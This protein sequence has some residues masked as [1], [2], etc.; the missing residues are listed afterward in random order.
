MAGEQRGVPGVADHDPA[1]AL[2]EAAALAPV[3][4]RVLRRRATIE[5]HRAARFE[6]LIRQP[7]AV[8][9][10][11]VA[12][13][14]HVRHLLDTLDVRPVAGALVRPVG[15]R[16]APRPV[17]GLAQR[18]L[19]VLVG[20][21]IAVVVETV[22]DVRRG[23]VLAA[24]IRLDVGRRGIA[25]H[26]LPIRR[27]LELAAGAG[28]HPAVA[29]QLTDP[30]LVGQPVAVVVHTVAALRV[31]LVLRVTAER[32]TETDHRPT[33]AEACPAVIA[34]A[35]RQFGRPRLDQ[36]LGRMGARPV[37]RIAGIDRAG[38]AIIARLRPPGRAQ[39]G[40]AHVVD[41]ASVAIVAGCAARHR[42]CLASTD[43]WNADRLGAARV[44]AR[45]ADHHAARVQHAHLG[46]AG[47]SPVAEVSVVVGG[48]VRVRL[49]RTLV[50]RR[51]HAAA[52]LAHV[53]RGARVAIV[54]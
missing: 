33:G 9:V 12:D 32:R 47:Q 29:T 38:L 27:A 26:P 13:L 17:A 43:L 49:A 37:V 8:I 24:R 3:L 48:A 11:V 36:R 54:A 42:Q 40:G 22:A 45:V 53:A 20:L 6:I 18:R 52:V 14:G 15:A 28:P 35:Q 1:F 51:A 10:D 41:R 23:L 30:G 39:P 21:T 25:D 19:E 4:A 5:L 31:G 7:V 44:P 46:R 16:V 2:T 34:Q 50:G